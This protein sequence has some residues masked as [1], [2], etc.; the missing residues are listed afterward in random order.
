MVA[1]LL[2]GLPADEIDV[3]SEEGLEF[4]DHIEIGIKSK[5]SITK[6]VE[7]INIAPGGVEIT[8]A[9]GGAED[10]EAEHAVAAAELGN[11]LAVLEDCGNHQA[12]PRTTGISR[13]RIFLRSVLRFRPSID[14][15]LI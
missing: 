14:A 7:K 13:S 8:P 11:C 5:A 12:T 3:P 15:A 6:I 4:I 1:A 9:C 2:D 10:L